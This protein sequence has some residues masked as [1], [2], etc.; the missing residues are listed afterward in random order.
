M[1]EFV[2]WQFWVQQ[3]ASLFRSGH[4][5]FGWIEQPY[6]REQ[7][8]LIPVDMFVG[9]FAI[10][11]ALTT[12]WASSTLRPVG[13]I[14]GNIV[15]ISMSWVKLRTNSSITRPWPIVREISFSLRIAAKEGGP[16]L[17]RV[18]FVRST[19][20]RTLSVCPL[21]S[22]RVRTFAPERFDAVCHGR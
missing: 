3:F 19:R 8:A 12:T 9:D 1:D 4:R 16:C 6:L 15:G 7:R 13:S 2:G 11:N 17:L 10:L 5:Q 21:R 22:D 14:P 20:F 18:I